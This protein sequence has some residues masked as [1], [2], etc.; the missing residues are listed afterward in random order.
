MSWK[1]N[2]IPLE[3]NDASFQ[4]IYLTLKFNYRVCIQKKTSFSYN[5]LFI[6]CL[7]EPNDTEPLVQCIQN[8]LRTVSYGAW[9]LARS[10]CH[11]Y[12]ITW[13]TLPWWWK[14]CN[15]MKT[16]TIDKLKLIHFN[17]LN[18]SYCSNLNGPQPSCRQQRRYIRFRTP[19]IHRI[20]QF[21]QQLAWF[22][23]LRY[24]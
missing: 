5:N 8:T 4:I 20:K 16:K 12:T 7:P 21:I 23:S 13:L 22:K 1:T 14:W 3:T 11:R 17:I 18:S 10:L 24:E 15:F 19:E 9:S 2:E 6:I